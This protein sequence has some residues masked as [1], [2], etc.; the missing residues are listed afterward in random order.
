MM[1]QIFSAILLFIISSAYAVDPK[2]PVTTIPAE[3]KEGTDVV[4]RSEETIFKIISKSKA[5]L[6]VHEV[7]TIFNAKGKAYATEVVGYDKLSRVVNF[8]ATAYDAS[9][10]QIKRLKNSDIYDQSSF[11][12][13]SLYSDNRLKVADLTQGSYPYTVEFDYELEY[14]FLFYIPTFVVLSRERVSLERSQYMLVY[15]PDLAPRVKAHNLDNLSP[16]QGKTKDGFETLTWSFEKMLPLKFESLGPL[17]EELFPRISAA[18]SQFAYEG[19]EGTMN[20]WNEFGQWIL[21][22]NKGRDQLPEETKN[23]IKSLTADLKTNEEKIKAVYEYLQSRSRYVS[24]QLG[25]GGFQP[26]EAS[27]VDKTGYGDC[28]ALSNYTVALLEAAG[29]KANYTL[30]NAGRNEPSMKTEFPS[31][32]F[33]HVVVAVPNGADTVWLECTSQTN[34]FGYMGSFTG[35]RNALMITDTGAKIV[36]TPRYGA[37]QNIQARSA[38]VI[39]D[40]AGNAKATVKTTYS[41]LQYENDGLHAILSNNSDDQKKWIQDNTQIPSFDIASFSM[42]NR[43]DKIPSATVNVSLVLNRFASVSGKRIF[44]T[45]NLMNRSTFIPEKIEV[46]K[47]TVVR[48]TPFIDIDTIRYQ[49]PEEIYPEFLPESVK[50][51]SRFGEYEASFKIDQGRLLYVRRVKMKKGEF[52]ADS[53][54]ELIEFYKNMNKADNTKIVFVTK[55]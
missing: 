35:D 4:I 44:I 29:I 8:D 46:R 26:F 7:Y 3:L 16:S 49:I 1:K 37:E 40:K 50:F 10:K 28:K 20:S 45:P 17:H 36:K 54:N 34:P 39:I 19:Y 32:Q 41:G 12:G 13:F 18:P 27:V 14:K 47:T 15:P 38:E 33:N 31:S 48:R 52:P 21:S 5:T 9:G 11:D 43:K 2:Y 25:I 24:I 6:H 23:K 42:T 53:Y 30:I 55:T 22:L 51:I